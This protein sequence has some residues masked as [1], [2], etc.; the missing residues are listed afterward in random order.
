[1]EFILIILSSFL[2][3]IPYY[4]PELFFLSFFAFIPLIYL[5]KDY[6]YNHSFIIAL[7]VGFLNSV[8]TLHWLYQPLDKVLKMPFSFNLFILF[9]YFLI[10]ALPF[11][12]WVVINKFLQPKKSYS[13]FIAAF[14]WTALEYF[15]FEFFNF[16]PFTYF[17]YSQSS[18]SLITQYASYGGV[19]LVSFISVLIASYLVKIYLDPSW[20]KAVPLFIIIIVLIVIPLVQESAVEDNLNSQIVDIAVFESEKNNNTFKKIEAEIDSLTKLVQKTNSKYIFTA[21][22]SISFDLIRNNYYRDLLKSKMKA[23]EHDFYLQLGSIAAAADSYNSEI[24]NSMFLLSNNLEVINR[25]S[26]ENNL[27][28]A[29]N[30][31]YKSEVILSI[32]DYLNLKQNFEKFS[33]KNKIIKIEE[34]SYLNLISNEIFIPLVFRKENRVQ[35]LNLI[36]NSAAED[37]INSKVYS[38]LTLAAAIY[39][40][41]E[42]NTSMLRVIR[43]GLSAYINGQGKILMKKR[44]DNESESINLVLQKNQSYYQRHPTKIID[45]LLV[46][47]IIIT[48]IKVIISLKNRWSSRN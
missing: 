38:N 16:N 6:D 14:S 26:K 39:R 40:A 34:L 43:G 3:T 4:F 20:K 13:P 44:L 47:F 11:A 21:E 24:S 19:I 5:I 29:V 48:I 2:F 41:A 7:L 18:F 22:K 12:V 8:F 9:L 37:I 25:S 28:T 23:D 17:A 46:I 45:I 27:L 30:F 42:T 33:N 36:V 31:P 32:K 1:M 35:D 15:R 10:C